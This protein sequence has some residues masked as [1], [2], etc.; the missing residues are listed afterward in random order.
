MK[1]NKHLQSAIFETI[2]NQI[3]AD[4]PPETA[5]TLTRLIDEGYSEYEAKQLIGQAI[6][7]E[8]WD[9]MRNNIP[10]NEKRYLQNLKNLPRE[11]N[12]LFSI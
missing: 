12:A 7:I 8:L 11:P 10:F 9:I 2:D 3:E 5:L 4:D 1:I 6:A